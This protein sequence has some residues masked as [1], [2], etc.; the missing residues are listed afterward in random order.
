MLLYQQPLH[1][2]SFA[3]MGRVLFRSPALLRPMDFNRRQ[4]NEG[5]YAGAGCTPFDKKARAEFFAALDTNP[6]HVDA[7]ARRC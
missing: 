4:V 6:R 7:P 1:I 2:P 5:C 3:L